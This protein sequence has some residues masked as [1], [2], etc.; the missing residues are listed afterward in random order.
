MQ[1]NILMTFDTQ[2]PLNGSR[3]VPRRQ[4]GGLGELP[5][6]AGSRVPDDLQNRSIRLSHASPHYASPAN[7]AITMLGSFRSAALSARE[8]RP[9]PASAARLAFRLA[10]STG[11]QSSPASDRRFETRFE[12]CFEPGLE[13]RF[14]RPSGPHFAR[15]FLPSSHSPVAILSVGG[16]ATHF[17]ALRQTRTMTVLGRIAVA[18]RPVTAAR[19]A[20][21]AST[22]H[23]ISDLTIA[24]SGDSPDGHSAYADSANTSRV[25]LMLAAVSSP[26]SVPSPVSVT[27]PVSLLLADADA[28]HGAFTA[29]PIEPPDMTSSPQAGTTPTGRVGRDAVDTSSHA[30]RAGRTLA[31][32]R[33]STPQLAVRFDIR[34]RAAASIAPLVLIAT[35]WSPLGGAIT[36]DA[37]QRAIDDAFPSTPSTMTPLLSRYTTDAGQTLVPATTSLLSVRPLKDTSLKRCHSILRIGHAAPRCTARPDM[38]H[39]MPD[40]M[41]ANTREIAQVNALR[42]VAHDTISSVRQSHLAVVHPRRGGPQACRHKMVAKV[43]PGAHLRVAAQPI[44]AARNVVS[45]QVRKL[46]PVHGISPTADSSRNAEACFRREV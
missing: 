9:F 19:P 26:V 46:S 35:Q 13:P 7:P 37:R 38:R 3:L 1:R 33:R 20:T 30:R 8:C 42:R 41:P 14:D 29:P 43:S 17:K 24:P 10:S 23:R 28:K 11:C 2:L 15:R 25:A 21:S 34:D 22:D 31:G 40:G 5:A 45:R 27:S 18:R 32:Q 16:Q 39:C 6:G 36:A 4:G 12:P 44:A